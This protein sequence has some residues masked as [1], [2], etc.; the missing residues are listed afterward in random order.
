MQ[1][2]LQNCWLFLHLCL[3]CPSL[4]LMRSRA[5]HPCYLSPQRQPTLHWTHP[6]FN[7]ITGCLDTRDQCAQEGGVNLVLDSPLPLHMWFQARAAVLA[8]GLRRCQR[9]YSQC[10]RHQSVQLHCHGQTSTALLFHVWGPCCS[11][12]ATLWKQAR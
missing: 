3:L 9:R 12:F 7:E 11:L 5:T 10:E 2:V 6:L 4:S 1:S 8:G